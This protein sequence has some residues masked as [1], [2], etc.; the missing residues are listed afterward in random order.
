MPVK[1]HSW[2]KQ[3][4]G[5]LYYSHIWQMQIKS[6]LTVLQASCHIGRIS[7]HSW[8]I[9]R[10]SFF[11]KLFSSARWSTPKPNCPCQF[12]T[13]VAKALIVRNNQVLRKSSPS[14]QGVWLCCC[15]RG[16]LWLAGMN[17]RS[18]IAG[19]DRMHAF[20]ATYLKQQHKS[21]GN[22]RKGLKGTVHR[23]VSNRGRLRCAA[24]YDI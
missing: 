15:H 13:W 8:H 23:C 14:R 5:C 11:S 18:P 12:G 6:C 2:K 9:C 10:Q 1:I 4:I 16:G 20:V 19:H 21:R 24:Q 7:M 17:L 22:V 3:T